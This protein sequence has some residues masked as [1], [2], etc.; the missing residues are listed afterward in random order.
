LGTVAN[1]VRHLQYALTVEFLEFSSVFIDRGVEFSYVIGRELPFA[2]IFVIF[3]ETD[4]D[5][6]SS[7]EII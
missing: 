7:R 4:E 3:R 6:S 1:T 2:G 5:F